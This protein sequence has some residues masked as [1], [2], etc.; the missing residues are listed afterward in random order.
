M[1]HMDILCR[2]KAIIHDIKQIYL[3]KC[4]TINFSIYNIQV[5][6]QR[7]G[8]QCYLRIWIHVKQKIITNQQ[9]YIKT[10]TNKLLSRQ[11]SFQN[12]GIREKTFNKDFFQDIQ[13]DV[14]MSR[15]SYKVI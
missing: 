6:Q 13:I 7:R 5:I 10:E 9:N 14:K 15:L 2:A 11:H 8:D 4:Q 3:N 1:N 12:F